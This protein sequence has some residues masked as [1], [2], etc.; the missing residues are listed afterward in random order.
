MKV[1]KLIT[2][3]A[4]TAS[5]AT[6]AACGNHSVAFG[7]YWNF[8]SLTD[9]ELYEKCVYAVSSESL[10]SGYA[11]YTVSYEGAYT[12]ILEYNAADKTYT[13]T[14]KLDVNATFKIN[15]EDKTETVADSAESKVVFATANKSLRPISSTKTMTCHTPLSGTF[16]DI[17]ACYSTVDYT[18]T[19]TY[20]QDKNGG[21][22]DGSYT[23][24]N[25]SYDPQTVTLKKSFTFDD[26]YTYIDN[27]QL[28]VATRAFSS[29]ASSATVETYGVFAEQTQKV[30][31]SFTNAEDNAAEPFTFTLTDKEGKA[32]EGEKSILC[33]TASISLNQTNPGATQKV[34]LAKATDASKNTYR[35]VIVQITTPLSYGMGNIVYKLTSVTYKK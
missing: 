35:N 17:A 34:K 12:T 26:D 27:E 21:S 16:S 18:Y 28:L 19:L 14:S 15:G 13:F 11:N 31:Y 24:K 30:K 8:S 29:D 7:H 23:V 32:V 25:Y 4:L 10:E 20:P 2:A 1:K 5:L 6:F 9:D 22:V 33:R 3:L